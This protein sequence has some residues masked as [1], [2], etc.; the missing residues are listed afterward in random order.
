MEALDAANTGTFGMPEP[1]K[2]RVT[3]VKGK[4][5]LVSGPRSQG[6]SGY[7]EAT[8]ETGIDIYTHGEMLP[9]MAI[10]ACTL[11]STSKAITAALGRINS[12]NSRIFRA[13]SSGG[14]EGRW[15]WGFKKVEKNL[16]W[17]EASFVKKSKKWNINYRVYLNSAVSIDL[18]EEDEDDVDEYEED[19]DEEGDEPVE[20]S[21]KPKS[22][23]WGP[24]FSSDRAGKYLK[25]L[26]GKKAFD[27][28]KPLEML[29]RIIA[30][31]GGSDSLILDFV[32]RERNNWRGSS[33]SQRKRRQKRRFILIEMVEGIAS[34]VTVPRLSKTVAQVGRGGFR[35]CTLGEPLFDADGNVSPAVTFPD[36]AAHV[37]FCETGSPVPRRADGSSPLSAR[38]RAAPSICCIPP[39]RS[40]SPAPRPAM[41]S[42]PPCCKVCPCPN[43]ASPAP[44]SSMPKVAPFPKTAC[45]AKASPSSKSPIKSRG[46]NHGGQNAPARRRNPPLHRGGGAI[47]VEVLFEEESFWL[48]Q[49]R[50]AELFEVTVRDD[51]RTYEKRLQDRGTRGGVSYSEIPD[52]C[53]RRQ[54]VSHKASIIS[55]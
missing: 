44:A 1:T 18:D 11:I 53:R 30:M 31:A 2:V 52:N 34:N 55:T 35:F 5:I 40:A 16:P 42:P 39:R 22:F 32:R 37:F 8:N 9:P 4:A 13:P 36:L 20:R 45:P 19:F 15:R 51:Q 47:R 49:K 24:E 38:S 21:T 26:I 3:P 14:V 46:C 33:S 50:M 12:S 28:P 54:E 25:K 7:L 27:Y 23:W 43:P 29:K 48:T 17:L 41:C 10:R 6:S